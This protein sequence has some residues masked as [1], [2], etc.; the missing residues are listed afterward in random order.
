MRATALG[1]VL[2]P[3]AVV[4]DRTAAW[5]HGVDA[6]RR[7]AVH[8]PPPLDVSHFTD[9]RMDR[10]EVDGRRRGLLPNDITLVHGIP[11]TTWL[12]TALDCGPVAVAIRRARSCR[13]LSQ[14]RRPA[15]ADDCRAREIQGVSWRDPGAQ[16][17][18]YRGSPCRVGPGVGT[19]TALVRRGPRP[20]RGAV[21][22]VLGLRRALVP[23]RP[24]GSGCPI[25]RGV[26][27]RG[28]SPPARMPRPSPGAA[29]P[30]QM[31]AASADTPIVRARRSLHWRFSASLRAQP[32]FPP[33][34]MGQRRSPASACAVRRHNPS[35][36]RAGPAR[37]RTARGRR[38]ST[39]VPTTIVGSGQGPPPSR[40]RPRMY[41]SRTNPHAAKTS[42]NTGSPSAHCHARRRS[43]G[44][45][46]VLEGSCDSSFGEKSRRGSSRPAGSGWP[47]SASSTTCGQAYP[48]TEGRASPTPLL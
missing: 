28:R 11:V 22:G 19:A 4:V 39:G 32:R 26:R 36:L 42:K 3:H 9:T 1:L 41:Q 45:N 31:E 43:T 7:S 47:R 23:H 12:R 14:A 44:P 10:P 24:R 46:E 48:P 40:R 27:R 17:G 20:A 29:T 2:P 15:R 18:V 16:S 33:P 21:V 25:W 8:S 30:A 6:L 38:R 34:P 35:S 13:R 37:P 5:L